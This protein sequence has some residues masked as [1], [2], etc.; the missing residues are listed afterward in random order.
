MMVF[1]EDFDL[2]VIVIE[3]DNVFANDHTPA[4]Y[5]EALCPVNNCD[6]KIRWNRAGGVHVAREHHGECGVFPGYTKPLRTVIIEIEMVC[7]VD[8]VSPEEPGPDPGTPF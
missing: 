3:W 8:V 1:C 6:I 2:L 5:S 4:S 7:N